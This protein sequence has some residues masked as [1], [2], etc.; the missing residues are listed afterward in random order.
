MMARQERTKIGGHTVVGTRIWCDRAPYD[1]TEEKAE[2]ESLIEHFL[3]D[4]AAQGHALI[5]FTMAKNELPVAL[6]LRK[7]SAIE[8]HV[9]R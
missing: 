1:V 3:S 6:V 4:P 5:H 2:V 8:H 7:I 9:E